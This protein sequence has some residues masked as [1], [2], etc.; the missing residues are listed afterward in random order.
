MEQ[1]PSLS[2]QSSRLSE[3][4]FANTVVLYLKLLQHFKWSVFSCASLLFLLRSAKYLEF[5]FCCAYV[6]HGYVAIC[7]GCL[8][9]KPQ[10]FPRAR[11]IQ[12]CLDWRK[13]KEV[14][15]LLSVFIWAR[16]KVYFEICTDWDCIMCSSCTCR[17]SKCIIP[18]DKRDQ[19]S[20]N[21]SRVAAVLVP[22]VFIIVIHL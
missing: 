10:L 5:G 18:W 16:E 6:I 14:F 12:Y 13:L 3:W 2:K 22:D 9:N 1:I 8:R 11:N 7:V 17:G 15:A 19:S 4:G 20:H 21:L